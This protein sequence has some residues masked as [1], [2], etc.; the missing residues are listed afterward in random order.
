MGDVMGDFNSRR[1]RIQGM[2]QKG[3]NQVIKAQV[4]LSEMLTYAST[5]KSLT[6]DRG[7]FTME[8]Y[9]Y[10]EVPAQIQTKIIE[11]AKKEKEA[12]QG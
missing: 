6:A 7:T 11:E 8:F 4:P 3:H 1:G 5:L 12:Q 2:S 9:Q 10:E